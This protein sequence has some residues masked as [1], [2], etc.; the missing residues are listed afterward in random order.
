MLE[1][2]VILPLVQRKAVD[3]PPALTITV[4]FLMG[5]LFGFVGLLLAAPLTVVIMSLV[6]QLY[7]ED[8]QEASPDSPG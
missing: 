8:P 6:K 2:Y 4:L 5:I 7:V 1:S 3:L